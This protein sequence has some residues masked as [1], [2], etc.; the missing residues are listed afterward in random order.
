MS[1]VGDFHTPNGPENGILPKHILSKMASQGF[2]APYLIEGEFFVSDGP[3]NT[4]DYPI[5]TRAG[6]SMG[7][8]FVTNIRLLFW[9]DD[10][11]MPHL[12]VFYGDIQAWKTTWMPMKSR[13]VNMVVSGKKVL[14]AANVT[15][16]ENA[17]FMIAK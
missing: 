12:G 16:V 8:L 2:I 7:R 6:Q 14:F 3:Y 1:I 15:A 10:T 9:S 5:S 13:A 17:S 4:K 11:S